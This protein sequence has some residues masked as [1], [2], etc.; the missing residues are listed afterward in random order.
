M[1]PE[2][3]KALANKIAE[4]LSD[5]NRL[6]EMSR[7]SLEIANKYEYNILVEKLKKFY[8]YVQRVTEEWITESSHE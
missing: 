7:T 5:V 8:S 6:N 3:E 1:P 4:V 2:N